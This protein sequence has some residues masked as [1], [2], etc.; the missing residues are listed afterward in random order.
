MASEGVSFLNHSFTV[1]TLM[2][3]IDPIIELA[4]SEFK[5]FTSSF[6]GFP[7]KERIR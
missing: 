1:L 5:E 7:V 4:T 3:L 6:E 2:K